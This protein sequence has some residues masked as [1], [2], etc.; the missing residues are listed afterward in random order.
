VVRKKLEEK[1]IS[2]PEV[3]KILEKLEKKIGV[4]NFDS[5]QSATLAYSKN[6]SKLDDLKKVDKIKKMLRKDYDLDENYVVMVINV[7]PNTVN[8]LRVIF[9]KDLKA[10]KLSDDNLQEMLY[11]IQDIVV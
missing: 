3:K 1:I 5:F 8:E 4:D 10:S 9:E 11:K 2:I 6:F 7:L